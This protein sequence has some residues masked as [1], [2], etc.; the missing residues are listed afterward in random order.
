MERSP[1]PP[2]T[3][4]HDGGCFECR[5]ECSEVGDGCGS[6]SIE[7]C[8]GCYHSEK[9][10]TLA[11]LCECVACATCHDNSCQNPNEGDES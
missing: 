11:A 2:A 6:S 4:C 5:R 3:I 9:C 8:A 1:N 10:D 7:E